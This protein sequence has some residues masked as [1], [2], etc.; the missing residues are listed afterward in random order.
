MHH[1]IRASALFGIWHLPRANGGE[2]FPRYPR[3]AHH[4]RRLHSSG[5]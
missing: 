2:P 1:H 4:A 3:P 5:G